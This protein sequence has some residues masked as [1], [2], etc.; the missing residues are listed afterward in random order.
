MIT[1]RPW[2]LVSH[3][4]IIGRWAS[5]VRKPTRSDSKWQKRKSCYVYYV[6]RKDNWCL[7]ES[8]RQHSLL[9]TDHTFGMQLVSPW[10]RGNSLGMSCFCVTYINCIVPCCSGELRGK[11]EIFPVKTEVFSRQQLWANPEFLGIFHWNYI[12]FWLV[13]F[14]H[15]SEKWWTNRQLGL[16]HSQYMESYK[17]HVPNHQPGL[18]LGFSLQMLGMLIQAIED[19]EACSDSKILALVAHENPQR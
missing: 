16:W 9:E 4:G 8:T 7:L 11:D 13:V 12:S 5:A 1:I 10:T 19:C 6:Y 2:S 18:I 15:P 14:R 17:I 3:L